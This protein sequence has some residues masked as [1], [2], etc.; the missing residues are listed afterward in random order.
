MEIEREARTARFDIAKGPDIRRTDGT[1]LSKGSV[2]CPFCEEITKVED[3]RSAGRAGLMGERMVAVILD[4]AHGKD[5]RPVE[6]GDLAAFCAAVAM[7][8]E[9]PSEPLLPEITGADADENVVNSTGIRV[10]SY[11]MTTWGS[12]FNP[13][14][15][16]AMQTFAACLQEA[17]GAM[18]REIE[19]EDYR[20]A[21]GVYL[22]L[23]LSRN[24]MRM[25]TLGRWHLSEEKVETPF[26]GA[27]LPMK[28]DYPEANP[29]S[30]VTGGFANQLDLMLRV[31]RR[32][33]CWATAP[34]CGWRTASATWS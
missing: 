9:R 26:D 31:I 21:V 29:F 7:D 17:L 12:L 22:G 14:Q 19:D 8:V 33:C 28:W 30:E 4:G 1:M 32:E 23:W 10:H 20:R 25:S 34:A 15:L 11:G 27:R 3:V 5:Y 6:E 13:R 2:R 18:S 16:V 24:S